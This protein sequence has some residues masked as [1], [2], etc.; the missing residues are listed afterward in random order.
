MAKDKSDKTEIVEANAAPNASEPLSAEEKQSLASKVLTGLGLMVAGA[1]LA[2]WAGPQIAPNLPAGLQPVADFFAPQ[3]SDEN[4]A[5]L[6]EIEDTLR[7]LE[8]R[9]NARFE[10]LQ[11]VDLETETDIAALSREIRSASSTNSSASDIARLDAAIDDLRDRVADLSVQLETLG[12]LPSSAVD[13]SELTAA[14]QAIAALRG[15]LARLEQ[16]QKT[17]EADL[18]NSSADFDA[19]LTSAQNTMSTV[20]EA[21]QLQVGT[22][23]NRQLVV[24]LERALNSGEPF[25]AL[26]NNTELQ[27]PVGLASVANVGVQT[28]PELQA[29]FPD[30]AYEAIRADIDASSGEGTVNRLSA[31]LQKQ[32]AVRSLE[33]VEGST[34][35]AILSRMEFALYQGDLGLVL[36]EAADLSFQPKAVLEIWL[37]QV[38]ARVNALLALEQVA[39]SGIGQ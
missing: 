21:A 14:N 1:V 19:R 22:A 13:G 4:S 29:A 12:E 5:R 30:L 20:T 9:T 7:G 6:T 17:L 34:T 38:A 3:D 31:F 16:D 18:A 24:E 28:L 27:L 23:Q 37:E 8:N 35:D 32:V 11:Q 10:D 2:L 15:Q 25:V 39:R 26:V 33:P 36:N